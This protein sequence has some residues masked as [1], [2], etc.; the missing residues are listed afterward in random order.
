MSKAHTSPPSTMI[1]DAFDKKQKQ[2]LEM[3]PDEIEQLAKQ[4]ILRSNEV[5]IWVRHLSNVRKHRQVGAQKPTAKRKGKSFKKKSGKAPLESSE[6][7]CI[8]GGPECGDMIACEHKDCPIKWF[9]EQCK[10][11]AMGNSP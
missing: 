9:H 10:G 2:G 3:T 11:V 4:T 1:K 6:L 8:C 5:E 7:W